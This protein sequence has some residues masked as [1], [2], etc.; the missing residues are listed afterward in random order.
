MKWYLKLFM[1]FI[2]INSIYPIYV[3]EKRSVG[4]YMIMLLNSCWRKFAI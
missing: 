1:I 3:K 4:G 2:Y